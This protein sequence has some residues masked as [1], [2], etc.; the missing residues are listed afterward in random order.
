MQ[1]GSIPVYLSDKH[2]LPWSDEIDWS[3]F[4]IVATPDNMQNILQMTLGMPASKLKTIQRNLE[5]VWE[6]HF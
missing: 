4:S 6:K 5:N 1:L 2:L 3:E